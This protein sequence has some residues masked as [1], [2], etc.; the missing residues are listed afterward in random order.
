MKRELLHKGIS[1]KIIGIAFE[2]YNSLGSGLPEKTYQ[3]A[4][5][6]EFRDQS[7][8][9][10]KEL[11]CEIKYKDYRVGFFRLD[12]L[13]EDKVAVEIKV[14]DEL[15]TKDIAQLLTYLKIKSV[16]VGLLIV[17]TNSGVEFKRLVY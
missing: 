10:E 2:I 13:V 15:Y 17:F 12:F 7:V 11:Y 6:K 5:E 3:L 4:M 1:G 14:R 8:N 9:Y 16:E